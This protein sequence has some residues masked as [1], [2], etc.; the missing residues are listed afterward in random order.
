MQHEI[1]WHEW[2]WLVELGQIFTYELTQE[3]FFPQDERT[4]EIISRQR[5][6]NFLWNLW[7]IFQWMES[8]RK[9]EFKSTA[10]SLQAMQTAPSVRNS[11]CSCVASTLSYERSRLTLMQSAKWLCST[12]RLN[13]SRGCSL[14]A[15][16]SGTVTGIPSMCRAVRSQQLP[17]RVLESYLYVLVDKKVRSSTCCCFM[18]SRLSPDT[19]LR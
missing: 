13:D 6:R 7:I 14:R 8:F 19:W 11:T 9:K 18:S 5:K 16:R 4:Q 2:D 1:T 12:K 10:E 3:Y 17:V 15:I